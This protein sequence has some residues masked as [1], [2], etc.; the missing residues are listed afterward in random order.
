M[1]VT[2]LT[3]LEKA[4]LRNKGL[5]DMNMYSTFAEGKVGI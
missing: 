4:W 1:R 2:A 5:R 3:E